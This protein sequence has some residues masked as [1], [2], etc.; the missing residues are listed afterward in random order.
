[1]NRVGV[2]RHVPL[3]SF[4]FGKHKIRGLLPRLDLDKKTHVL[5]VEGLERL[6]VDEVVELDRLVGAATGL[7][8]GLLLRLGLGLER[9]LRFLR[10]GL[11]LGLLYAVDRVVENMTKKNRQREESPQS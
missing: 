11:Q 10:G 6:G 7:G 4:F 1:M 2:G 8:G 3:F 9:L 5:L